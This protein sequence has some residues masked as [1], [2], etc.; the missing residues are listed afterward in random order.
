MRSLVIRMVS[1]VMIVDRFFLFSSVIMAQ[2]GGDGNE[3]DAA[4][5]EARLR[6]RC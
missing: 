4:G 3:D 1:V 5:E 2:I 6:V